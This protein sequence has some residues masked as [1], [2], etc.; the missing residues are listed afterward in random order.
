MFFVIWK[1]YDDYN[2]SEFSDNQQQQAED[3]VARVSS[4]PSHI[5]SVI[6]VIEGKKIDWKPISIVEK[7]KFVR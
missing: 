1:D 6:A 5:Q 2:V 4:G 3:L 7:V